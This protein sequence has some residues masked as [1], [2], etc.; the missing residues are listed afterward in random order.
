MENVVACAYLP[1]TDDIAVRQEGTSTRHAEA[2]A[3][4]NAGASFRASAGGF[5][6]G[7]RHLLQGDT[8]KHEHRHEIYGSA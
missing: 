7:N 1:P 5:R 3:C 8:R 2:L 4:K 6:R